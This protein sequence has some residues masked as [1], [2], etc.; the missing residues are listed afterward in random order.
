VALDGFRIRSADLS[1]KIAEK[2][3][4][5]KVLFTVLR[6]DKLR[7]FTAILEIDPIP[8]YIVVKTKNPTSLQKQIYESWLGTSWDK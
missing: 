6:N 1:A 7:E 3:A 2:R 5:D 8:M 4:G